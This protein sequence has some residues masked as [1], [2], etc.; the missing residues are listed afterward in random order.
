M[1]VLAAVLFVAP[2]LVACTNDAEAR[3]EKYHRTYE[4][5]VTLQKNLKQNWP[6]YTLPNLK[7]EKRFIKYSDGNL[8]L[9][10]YV[11][12]D[13]DSK[14]KRPGVLVLHDWSGRDEFEEGK[15]EALAALGYVG[16]AIDV[17]GRHGTSP[18][19]NAALMKQFLDNR[20]LLLQRLKLGLDEL[21]KI[22]VL[23]QNQIGAIGFCFGGMGVLDMSRASW[24]LKGVVSFHGVLGAPPQKY[25]DP[26]KDK[27]L[28]LHGHD[29]AG[30]RPSDVQALEEELTKR[31]ADWQVHVYSNTVHGWTIPG[32][33]YNPLSDKRSWLSMKNFFQEVFV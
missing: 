26:V 25:S 16:F 20:P 3:F 33:S 9:T 22:D 23:D 21:K 7:L 11:A 32:P 17:Y 29:D 2:L 31:K 4:R 24:D 13:S 19:D 14:A 12:Y 1:L 5:E 10:G 18:A 27:I 15:A 6:R 30:V 8:T 28:V